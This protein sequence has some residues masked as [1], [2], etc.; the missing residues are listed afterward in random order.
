MDKELEVKIKT[1]ED[2]ALKN[3]EKKFG[4]ESYYFGNK[5]LPKVPVLCSTGSLSLDSALTIGG[6]PQGRVIEIG[7]WESSGKSSLCLINIAA[8]QKQNM[9]CGYIDIEQSFDPEYAEKLGVDVENLFIT[10]PDTI[11]DTFGMLHELVKS[12]TFSLIVVDST[13]AMVTRKA[14]E[15]EVGDAEMGGRARI[16]STELAKVVAECSDNNCTVIFLS[17]VRSKIGGYGNPEV[18]GI[19]NAMRFSA[20]IRIKTSSPKAELKKDDIEG[21]TSIEV[22]MSVFKNKVGV[23]FKKASFTLLTGEGGRYGIDMLKEVIDYAVKFEI[24]KKAGTWYS[25]NE[26]RM[27]QGIPNVKEYLERNT[28]ILN[29][30]KTKVIDVLYKDTDSKP[31]PNSFNAVTQNAVEEETPSPKKRGRK[32]KEV[33]GENLEETRI[34]EKS[35]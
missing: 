4:K 1:L 5:K 8:C 11:E 6:F 34:E 22:N 30:M 26:E 25:Y 27:G 14:I 31:M 16:L 15:G 9:L 21:Q 23:P 29:E 17:Q 18:I 35:E 33:S 28:E 2:G 20:S 32:P 12:K 3:I 13:N 19:G 24:I 7:G 10:Q